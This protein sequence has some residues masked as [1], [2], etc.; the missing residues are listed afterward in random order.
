LIQQFDKC[1][2][3]QFDKCLIQQFDKCLIQQFDKCLIQQ[4]DKCLIQQFDKSLLLAQYCLWKMKDYK[5]AI[6]VIRWEKLLAFEFWTPK[7]NTY[8]T[9]ESSNLMCA[10]YK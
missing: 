1:L 3:Q 4:F 6:R 8:Q 2:I 5:Y 9:A 7:S 10:I